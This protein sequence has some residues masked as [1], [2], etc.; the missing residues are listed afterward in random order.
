MIVRHP[1]PLLRDETVAHW[2]TPGLAHHH[3]RCSSA[4]DHLTYAN[5]CQ[6]TSCALSRRREILL[7]S[8]SLP[9]SVSLLNRNDLLHTPIVFGSAQVLSSISWNLISS[10]LCW[11]WPAQ[12]LWLKPL[13][14]EFKSRVETI[15]LSFG[16]LHHYFC[17][18]IK[19]MEVLMQIVADGCWWLND[20]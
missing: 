10:L 3:R 16:L 6:K 8:F 13:P 5:P 19:L 12:L 1:V 2:R 11:V 17:S 4:K 18:C 14:C 20:K 7:S 9:R 15:C